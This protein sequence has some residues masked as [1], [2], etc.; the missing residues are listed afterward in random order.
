MEPIPEYPSAKILVDDGVVALIERISVTEQD[1]DKSGN[2]FRSLIIRSTM[3]YNSHETGFA[4]TINCK[5]GTMIARVTFKKI[6]KN[7][8]SLFGVHLLIN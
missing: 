1:Q 4:C 6:C 8:N 2:V 3:L 5:I 7:I